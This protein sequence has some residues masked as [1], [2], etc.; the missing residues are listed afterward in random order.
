MD[1]D[2]ISHEEYYGYMVSR[3]HLKTKLRSVISECKKDKTHAKWEDLVYIEPNLQ[4]C[5][6]KVLSHVIE[7]L[8]I[9]LE[10]EVMRSKNDSF[11]LL[12][13]GE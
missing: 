11:V 4:Y 10:Y 2:R 9:E 1:R 5:N 12:W 13:P 8:S 7:D 3:N 6:K